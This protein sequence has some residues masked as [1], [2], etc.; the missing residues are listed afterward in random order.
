MPKEGETGYSGNTHIKQSSLRTIIRKHMD[1]VKAIH[2]KQ[3]SW[4]DNKIYLYLDIF[5]GPGNYAG[6]EG[7]PLIA[8]QEAD[9]TSQGLRINAHF[10]EKGQ[11]EYSKLLDQCKTF[12]STLLVEEFN[13]LGPGHRLF[14][15]KLGEIHLYNQD[16]RLWIPRFIESLPQ[17]TGEVY[18]LI[19][20]DP[21]NHLASFDEI[22]DLANIKALKRTDILFHLPATTFKRVRGANSEIPRLK[23][24]L[25]KIQKEYWFIREP[26]GQFQ[27]TFALGTNWDSFPEFKNLGFHPIDSENGRLV[28]EKLDCTANELACA[29]KK[30][31][32]AIRNTSNILNLGLFGAA[33]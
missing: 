23:D 4:V 30:T 10:C 11:G 25:N 17:R 2:K 28:F 19:Y 3:Y 29:E 13:E 31:I 22:A 26:F 21:N 8:L 15:D 20:S 18:G 33:S 12:T 27:W 24:Q 6:F 1:I 7:S 5:A 32:P 16:N 14:A 9:K